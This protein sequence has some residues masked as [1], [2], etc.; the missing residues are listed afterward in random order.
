MHIVEMVEQ[1][2]RGVPVN[3]NAQKVI[4]VTKISYWKG[5][6]NLSKEPGNGLLSG[7]GEENVIHINEHIQSSWWTA[8]EKQGMICLRLYKTMS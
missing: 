8:I 2:S 1:K 3:L 5:S 6:L 4:K 7:A